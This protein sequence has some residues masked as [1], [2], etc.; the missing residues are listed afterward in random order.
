MPMRGHDSDTL[1]LHRFVHTIPPQDNCVARKT[2][3]T[4]YWGAD[5]RAR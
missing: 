4:D 5:L 3:P 1:S 2:V